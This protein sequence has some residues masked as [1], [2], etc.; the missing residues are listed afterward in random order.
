MNQ[1]KYTAILENFVI[2]FIKRHEHPGDM[3][4]IDDNAPYHRTALVR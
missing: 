2:K 4:Y 3:F 1:Q